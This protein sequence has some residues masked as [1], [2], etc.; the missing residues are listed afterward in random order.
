[1][2]LCFVNPTEMHRAAIYDLASQLAMKKGYEI[3]VLQPSDR[4]TLK[5]KDS[6]DDSRHNLEVVYLPSFFLRKFYYTL[7]FFRKQVR[8]LCELVEDLGCQIIQA[9]DYYYPTSIAPILVEKRTKVPIVLSSNV[10]PGYSWFYRDAIVDR[11]AKTYTYGIGKW[12]LNSYDQIILLYTRAAKDVQNFGVPAERVLVIPNGVDFENFRPIPDIDALRTKLSIGENDRVLLFVGRLAKVKRVEIL[13][14]LTKLLLKEGFNIKTV[15]VG[16]GPCR[17]Y[18]EKLAE[19]IRKNVIF[20]GWVHRKQTYKYY[21]IADVFVL[22]SLSEGLPSVLLEASA[23][24]KPSVASDVN[25]VSD[26]VVHGE[27]GYLVGKSDVDSY[28]QYVKR[29]LRGEDLARSMGARATEHVKENFNWDVIVDEYEK[30]YRK[31]SD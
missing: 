23:A 22:P 28:L 20:T 17:E 19:P 30:L 11:I 10:F 26:I 2:K 24:G 1:M 6:S 16:D 21:H 12:I 15:I 31:I 5:E 18:Y 3:T 8:I 14:A 25:G 4:S 29:L 27:T 9:C 7:P 13:I